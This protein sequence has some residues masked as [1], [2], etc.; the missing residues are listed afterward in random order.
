MAQLADPLAPP[1][2]HVA[3]RKRPDLARDIDAGAYLETLLVAAVSSV[4]LTRLYL[5]MTGYPRIGGGPLHLA[6]LLWGG[7]LMLIGLVLLLSM[8][9]KRLKH[10][11]AAIGGVGFGLFI[12]EIGKF[13][14]A[15]NN[16]F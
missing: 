16:Y 3:R 6:H 10:F 9:G 15:D 2:P 11:A 8:L 4:L 1:T 5:G 7:L 13:V 14:T 12:D